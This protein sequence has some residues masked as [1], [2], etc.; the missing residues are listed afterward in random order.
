MYEIYQIKHSPFPNGRP[1]AHHT[2][3]WYIL[4]SFPLCKTFKAQSVPQCWKSLR[5]FFSRSFFP[6]FF[7]SKIRTRVISRSLITCFAP[8]YYLAALSLLHF[9]LLKHFLP[10]FLAK[11]SI[12]IL[13]APIN[14]LG[15]V[16]PLGDCHYKKYM[17]HTLNL[18]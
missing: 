8:A 10:Y 11:A 17:S 12:F 1:K 14:I 6:P 3:P 2:S 9:C 16:L 15:K 13:F 18:N 7:P 4:L 5:P